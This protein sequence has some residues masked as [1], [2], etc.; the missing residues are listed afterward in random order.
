MNTSYDEI[1]E[2]Q[3]QDLYP[4]LSESYYSIP[5]T[6]KSLIDLLNQLYN[7]EQYDLYEDILLFLKEEYSEDFSILFPEVTDV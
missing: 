4:E 1:V 6:P 5:L 2:A 7:N 3:P